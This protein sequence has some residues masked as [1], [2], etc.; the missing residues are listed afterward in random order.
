MAI[1]AGDKCP[2]EAERVERSRIGEVL[3]KPLPESDGTPDVLTAFTV[4]ATLLT[5]TLRRAV[6]DVAACWSDK[7]R[8]TVKL[9]DGPR[10]TSFR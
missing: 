8:L 9:L 5:T 1:A 3:P 6:H 2:Q 7:D 10:G 4:G